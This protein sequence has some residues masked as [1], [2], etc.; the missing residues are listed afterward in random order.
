MIA[1]PIRSEQIGP[2]VIERM[3]FALE[4]PTTGSR[5]IKLRA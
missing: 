2:A 3:T 5:L 4:S 1:R